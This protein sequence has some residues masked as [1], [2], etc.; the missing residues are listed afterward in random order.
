MAR[1]SRPKSPDDSKRRKRSRDREKTRDRAHPDFTTMPNPASYT[2]FQYR[3]S[4]PERTTKSKK[5]TSTR[6]RARAP[7]SS[8]SGSSSAASSLLDISRH[9][10]SSRYGG[11]FRAFFRAPSERRRRARRSARA[12]RRRDLYFAGGNSSSSSVNSD[13]AYGHGYIPKM[14]GRN[15]SSRNV[16]AGYSSGRNRGRESGGEYS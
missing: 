9:Y 3:P 12:N 14:K 16:A 4:S 5:R 8:S 13:L 11:F 7:S 6:T 2:N 10:P 1:E 15:G